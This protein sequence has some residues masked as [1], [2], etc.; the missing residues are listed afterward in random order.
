MRRNRQKQQAVGKAANAFFERDFE[1]E[2]VEE[3]EEVAKGEKPPFLARCVC[4]ANAC[5]A[6][7]IC[8]QL[9]NQF[10]VF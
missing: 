2:E 6:A 1:Q 7:K 9:P 4:L 8:F 10:T 5:L 3:K